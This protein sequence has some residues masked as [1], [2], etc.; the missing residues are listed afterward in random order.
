MELVTRLPAG[1]FVVFVLAAAIAAVVQR[2]ALA[3]AAA[4]DRAC[5]AVARDHLE[6]GRFAAGVLTYVLFAFKACRYW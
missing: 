6:R 4:R 1:D 3:D 5:L 2:A